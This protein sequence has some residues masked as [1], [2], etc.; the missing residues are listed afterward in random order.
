MRSFLRYQNVNKFGSNFILPFSSLI[1]VADGAE[2]LQRQKTFL[3]EF[4]KCYNFWHLFEAHNEWNWNGSRDKIDEAL[5]TAKGKDLNHFVIKF[6]SETCFLCVRTFSILPS[7]DYR[8]ERKTVERGKALSSRTI[9]ASIFRLLDRIV[10]I[11]RSTEILA[12]VL[13]LKFIDYGALSAFQCGLGVVSENFM[14]QNSAFHFLPKLSTRTYFSQSFW[15]NS[16]IPEA[17]LIFM[18]P[19]T[20]VC[21]LP[22]QLLLHIV[23]MM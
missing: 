16:F 22:T 8:E 15:T 19:S 14:P 7:M 13:N 21:L 5:G 6:I 3:I 2:N 11:S 23:F 1:K 9:S 10:S 18:L 12:K 17:S 20:D 4:S